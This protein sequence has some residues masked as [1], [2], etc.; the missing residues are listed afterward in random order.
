MRC[1]FEIPWYGQCKSEAK[2][3]KEFCGEHDGVIC[4]NKGCGN[5]ATHE[6]PNMSQFGCGAPICD[7]CGKH[8]GC[9]TGTRY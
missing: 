3:D 4:Y 5:Q 9:L 6:C 8:F 1:K 2:K 7:E